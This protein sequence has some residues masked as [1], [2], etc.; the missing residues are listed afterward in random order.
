MLTIAHRLNTI[1]DSDRLLVLDAG[2]IV[3]NDHPYKLLQDE[4]GMFTSMVRQTGDLMASN[5]YHVARAAY[6]NIVNASEL[7][8]GMI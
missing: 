6:E 1:M 3:E 7:E 2:Q 5:L 4:E 8:S